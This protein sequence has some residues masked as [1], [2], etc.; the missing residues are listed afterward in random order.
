M[1]FV[2]VFSIHT[3]SVE[4][5]TFTVHHVR[6]NQKYVFLFSSLSVLCVNLSSVLFNET[7]DTEVKKTRETERE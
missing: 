1:F 4:I 7:N 3:E 5:G 6:K 2:S